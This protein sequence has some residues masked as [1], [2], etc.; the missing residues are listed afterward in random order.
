MNP[1]NNNHHSLIYTK[2]F[3][4]LYFYLFIFI[5]D[6]DHDGYVSFQF[7]RGSNICVYTLHTDRHPIHWEIFFRSDFPKSAYD[8]FAREIFMLS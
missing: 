3:K 1:V 8:D 6:E 4:E 5:F 7:T 2:D